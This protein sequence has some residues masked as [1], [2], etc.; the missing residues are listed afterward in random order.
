MDNGYEGTFSLQFQRQ[1]LAVF[2]RDPKFLSRFRSVVQPGYFTN[3]VD[4][5]ICTALLSGYDTQRTV[6]TRRTLAQ[7]AADTSR[8]TELKEAVQKRVDGLYK[9]DI[10]DAALVEE[11]ALEFGRTQALALA[12]VASAKDIMKG[13]MDGVGNRIKLAQQV[14]QDITDI[15]HNYVKT[16]ERRMKL[17]RRGK[18]TPPSIPTG[19]T[20]LDYVLEGGGRRGELIFILAAP[21]GGKSTGLLNVARGSVQAG[22]NTV[23]LSF[24]LTVPALEDRF[25]RML[26]GPKYP[27]LHRED[28]DRFTQLLQKRV[29]MFVR[30]NLIFHKMKKKSTPNQVAN[31]LDMLRAEGIKVDTLIIDHADHMWP[32]YDPRIRFDSPTQ[33]QSEVYIAIKAMAEE[34]DVLLYTASQSNRGGTMQETLTMNDVSWSLDKFAECDFGIGLNQTPEERREGKARIGLIACR[35]VESD[36][37]IAIAYD[38]RTYHMVSEGL[39]TSDMKR[40]IHTREDAAND[41]DF[42]NKKLADELR[43]DTAPEETP[44]KRRN[45]K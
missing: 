21:K 14:G 42:H 8:D 37:Q 30:G 19:F 36:V 22:F 18:L 10:S 15:G 40:K 32:D 16:L 2:C 3:P 11:K 9:I 20:H 13:K 43:K 33:R 44:R 7:L 5:A 27:N 41:E 12:V 45:S 1:L 31:Y 25:D 4:R 35:R 39:Y 6:P 24:E 34:Q 23:Y 29:P 26:V 38:K 17:R 28:P